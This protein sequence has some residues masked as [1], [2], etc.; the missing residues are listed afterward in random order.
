M[1]KDTTFRIDPAIQGGLKTLSRL[2]GKPVNKLVNDALLQYVKAQA[3][4]MEVDLLREYRDLDP[5]LSRSVGQ[6][7]QREMGY[8]G[9]DPMEGILLPEGED[10]PVSDRRMRMLGTPAAPSPAQRE[11]RAILK[12][13]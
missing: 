1:S 9:R 10:A 13:R 6:A 7:V 12:R 3:G 5:D 8:V 2:L 4:K 11:L